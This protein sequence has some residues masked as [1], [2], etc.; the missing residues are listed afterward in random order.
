MLIA[1]RALDQAYGYHK[2]KRSGFGRGALER[3]LRLKAKKRGIPERLLFPSP[4]EQLEQQDSR[5][6]DAIR[7]THPTSGERMIWRPE[8][9]VDT[10]STDRKKKAK[11]KKAKHQRRKKGKRR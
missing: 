8:I 1:L 10:G 11:K 7:F 6:D 5:D 9:V 2:E 3:S 4:A